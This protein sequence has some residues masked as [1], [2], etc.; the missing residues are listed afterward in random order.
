[1]AFAWAAYP[2]T[3]FALQANSNDALLAAFL[4][5]S[6]ALFA[7]PL[8]RGALLALAVMTKF[9]P[10]ALAPLYAA[11]DQRAHGRSSDARLARCAA[12]TADLRRRLSSRSRRS[13]WP[14][15]RSTRASRPSSTAPSSSQVDRTS[16][17]SIWGQVDGIQWVQT[18]VFAAVALFATAL[19]F[20]PRRRSIA[21][22]SRRCRP[23]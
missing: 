2:Y 20:V 4:A 23:R 17:F 11:G 9:A 10:L 18:A 1:M 7:R 19:A 21:A 13:C 3:A 12:T 22:R 6:L 15:R 14:T 16:P 8:A 5:W